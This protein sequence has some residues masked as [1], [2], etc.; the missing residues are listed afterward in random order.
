MDFS[1]V[2]CAVCAMHDGVGQEASND[3]MFPSEDQFLEEMKNLDK[4]LPRDK[5][6]NLLCEKLDGVCRI[7]ECY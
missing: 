6:G 5:D 1:Y 7:L 3:E 2:R 4:I